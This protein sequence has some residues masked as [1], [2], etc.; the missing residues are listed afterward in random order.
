MFV[1]SFILKTMNPWMELCIYM[2]LYFCCSLVFSYDTIWNI[3]TSLKVRMNRRKRSIHRS[4]TRFT[5]PRKNPEVILS[6]FFIQRTK[7]KIS[8]TSACRTLP[9]KPCEKW[10]FILEFKLAQL[11]ENNTNMMNKDKKNGKGLNI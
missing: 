9:P 4:K 7:P 2:S 11:K 1:Y 5:F 8:V 10:K 3:I 6:L